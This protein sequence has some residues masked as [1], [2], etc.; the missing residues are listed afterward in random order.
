MTVLMKDLFP[1]THLS[2]PPC[3]QILSPKFSPVSVIF[4]VREAERE[5]GTGEMS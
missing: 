5:I 4:G 3:V 2:T 1:Q